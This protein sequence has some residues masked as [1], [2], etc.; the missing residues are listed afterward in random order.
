MRFLRVW[1]LLNKSGS[2]K[3][4]LVYFQLTLCVSRA[5]VNRLFAGPGAVWQLQR[6]PPCS[7]VYPE[8]REV[9]LVLTFQSQDSSSIT[10]SV[11][12]RRHQWPK[13]PVWGHEEHKTEFSDW[14]FVFSVPQQNYCKGRKLRSLSLLQ[15]N[16]IGILVTLHLI[17]HTEILCLP[18]IIRFGR[19][20]KR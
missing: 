19:D 9:C 6:R 7:P 20:K 11:S 2:D 16:I 18:C 5:G 3:D 12:H 1:E 10:S 15:R 4:T 17:P 14:Q 8:E 13:P